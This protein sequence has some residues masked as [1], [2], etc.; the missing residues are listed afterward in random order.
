MLALIMVPDGECA[1]DVG[2]C[3]VP[4]LILSLPSMAWGVPHPLGRGCL[5]AALVPTL[6][7][8]SILQALL[9]S[10]GLAQTAAAAN[11]LGPALSRALP[12]TSDLA[13]ADSVL[14][15]VLL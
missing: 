15:L 2:I 8:V 12:T 14:E 4:L 5:A 6:T 7:P 3:P 1:S 10:P 9:G 13:L 11:L